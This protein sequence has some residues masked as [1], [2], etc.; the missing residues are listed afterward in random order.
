MDL[1]TLRLIFQRIA[2]AVCGLAMSAG[3]LVAQT[4]RVDV[5]AG[6]AIA[7]DPDKAMGS[8]MDILSAKQFETV[9]SAPIIKESLSAGWGADHL[10]AEHGTDD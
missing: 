1:P 8:S 3:V 4:V 10:P 7:F 6:A 9:Y 2:V 5:A